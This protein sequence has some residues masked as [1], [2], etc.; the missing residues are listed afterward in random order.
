MLTNDGGIRS[1]C[2]RI[3]RLESERKALAADIAEIKTEAKGMGFDTALIGKTVR[4]MLLS[5]AR[6]QAALDQ[7]ELFDTYL[8][9]AGLLPD[10]PEPA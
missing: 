7:L 4:I 5:G 2:E 6:R 1:I 9:A 10:T 8:G 3:A